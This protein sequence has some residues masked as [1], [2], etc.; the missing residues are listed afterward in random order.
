MLGWI[1][2]VTS[3]NIDEL[4]HLPSGISHWE[5]GRFELYRV[6]PPLIRMVG[7]IPVMLSG[8]E[9]DWSAWNNSSPFAR[10]EFWVGKDFTKNNADELFWYFT[11]ARWA[12]IPLCLIGPWICFLWSRELYG[13]GSGL[14]A[15][16]LYC[17]C[18]QML[19]WGS[20]ITPDAAAASLGIWAAYSFWR[21]LRFPTWGN[22]FHAGFA[23]GLAELTKTTWIVLFALWPVIWLGWHYTRREHNR[24]TNAHRDERQMSN[25]IFQLAVILLI[26]IYLINLGYGFSGSLKP[27]GKY[28]FISQSLAGDK[29][30]TTGGNRF[31]G[32]LLGVLPVPFPEDYVRGIDVQK[33]D[34]EVG[35][36]S[37]LRGEQKKGGWWYY[38]LYGLLVKTPVG[39]LAVFGLGLFWGGLW[40]SC[41]FSLAEEVIL[42]MPA[43]VVL[44][45]VSSQTGFNRYVRYVVPALPFLYIFASRA[46][47]VLQPG[48]QVGRSRLR[49]RLLVVALAVG[50]V[51]SC[52]CFPHSMSFFNIVAG[53]PRVGSDHLVD[54]NID[55]GQDLQF[56]K[57]WYDEN[58]QA[59]PI[60]VAYFEDWDI[61]PSVVGLNSGVIPRTQVSGNS[62][63]KLDRSKP[64]PGWFAVSV[65]YLQGYHYF[66]ND[67]SIYTW[68]RQCVPVG[69]A[70]YSI[71]IYHVTVEQADL[72]RKELGLM[73][74]APADG[75]DS[76]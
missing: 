48:G 17:C 41:R 26:S 67:E 72:L 47:M 62:T 60:H 68:L 29:V 58:P 73:P 2:A 63:Q 57:R 56:L 3:P 75:A 23:L 24:P 27:L 55:W 59:R 69:Q 76:G 21:W 10:S 6:N 28:E 37:Y 44:T 18:P 5:F 64:H 51:E 9:T 7:T 53:G 34:F 12:C 52:L 1:S 50:A 13:K 39:A 49:V 71:R 66:E 38:Y 14:V 11:M 15:V 16:I 42:L 25:Q 43:I 22:V 19:A 36:W 46:G 40:P 20:S 54:A 31:S 70:G 8:P 33:R 61:A 45:L 32:T 4:A 65:N 30:S 35:K 74:F